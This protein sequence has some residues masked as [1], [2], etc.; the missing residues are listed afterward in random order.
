MDS[1]KEMWNRFTQS[2]INYLPDL[3]G[4]LV[5]TVIG[6]IISI[7]LVSLTRKA[8]QPGRLYL[9]MR[10]PADLR[11]YPAR[12]HV[13]AAYLYHGYCRVLLGGCSGSSLG[14]E[15]PTQRYR[16]RYRDPVH[17]TLCHGRFHRIHQVL[18][19]CAE[20]RRHAHQHPHLRRF[21]SQ[22]PFPSPMTQISSRCKR[23]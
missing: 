7:I 8:L 18:G 15:R 10:S 21:V 4:A 19:L 9:P 17:Q 20:D 13:G 14:T 16:Q 22:S 3:G 5:I 12:R 23:Y 2:I 1:I 11:L 6:I